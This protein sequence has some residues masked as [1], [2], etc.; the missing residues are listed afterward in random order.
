MIPRGFA[1]GALF[2]VWT[3]PVF[4]RADEISKRL[5]LGSQSALS[6]SKIASG[7]KEAFK[8]GVTK[9]VKLTGKRDGYFG[10]EAIEILRP[11]D[12]RPVEKGL[13]AVG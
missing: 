6:D 7:L 10:N 1:L 3:A 5:G 13:R 4:A 8:V 12:L 2:L 11:K 9:G